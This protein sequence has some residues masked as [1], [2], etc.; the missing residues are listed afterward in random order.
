MNTGDIGDQMVYVMQWAAARR[1]EGLVVD[2]TQNTPAAFIFAYL[3]NDKKTIR[4][5]KGRTELAAR[6]ALMEA[7]DEKHGKPHQTDEARAWFAQHEKD[8]KVG[9]ELYRKQMIDELTAEPEEENAATEQQRHLQVDI[10]E[11]GERV[12]ILEGW[13]GQLMMKEGQR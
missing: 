7:G 9:R 11:I 2:V 12:A 3:R 8:C 4:T 6:L 10:I 13:V 5:G 1:A